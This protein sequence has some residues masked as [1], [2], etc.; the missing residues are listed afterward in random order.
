MGGGGEKNSWLNF[1]YK[2]IAGYNRELCRQFDSF[3]PRAHWCSCLCELTEQLIENGEEKKKKTE[4]SQV[5]DPWKCINRVLCVL[6][7]E[8]FFFWGREK[9][10]SFWPRH[11]ATVVVRTS[12]LARL[13]ASSAS[14]AF[15]KWR[16]SSFFSFFDISSS[17][18][19]ECSSAAPNRPNIHV[20]SCLQSLNA[21]KCNLGLV[22]VIVS[23][24]SRQSPLHMKLNACTCD[25][26]TRWDYGLKCNE[27]SRLALS[28]S[29]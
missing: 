18:A 10:R 16:F 2:V 11:P 14:L 12:T 24:R 1:Y 6:H 4:R 20:L 27:K 19:F 26:F 22:I 23:A 8:A 28:A 15:P 7:V 3:S 21:S 13:F 29:S 9:V 25:T 5:S 17:S